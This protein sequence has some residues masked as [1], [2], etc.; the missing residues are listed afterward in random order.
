M[1]EN[2]LGRLWLEGH[3][4]EELQKE[5]KYYLEEAEQEPE[6]EEELKKIR[7]EH[8][9]L[10]PEDIKVLDPCMG[11]GHILV[12]AFD[13]LYQIYKEA[14]YGEREIPRKIL[15]NNLYGLDI[16]DRAAQLA[17][18]ALI[19]KARGYNRRLFR[20]IEREELELNLCSIQESNGISEEAIE[21]FANGNQQ[22]KED[23]EYLV[24]VFNYAKEYGS[25]LE[26]ETVNFEIINKRLVEVEEDERFIFGDYRRTIIDKVPML[27]KQC[28]VISNKYEI[29]VTNP[30]YMGR[31][32]MKD[33]LVAYLDD[34]YQKSKY[35]MSTVFMDKCREY[36]K[37]TGY[38]SMINIPSWMFLS[39]YQGLRLDI[40][41]NNTFVNLLHNGRG[42]FGSDFGTTAFVINNK[43]ISNYRAIFRK[44]FLNQGEVDSVLEKEKMFFN[45]YGVYLNNQ[46]DFKMIES[47]PIAYWATDIMK[48]IFVEKHKLSNYAQPKVGLQTGENEKFLRLWSEVDYSNIGLNFK[49]REIAKLSL[50]KWF[51]YNKGGLFRKWYGNNEYIVNWKN[52][53]EEIRGFKDNKGKLK[54]RPQNLEYYFEEGITWSFVSSSNFGVRYSPNGFIFD[55]AGSS[56]FPR[57]E[58]MY[59]IMAILGSKLSFEFLKVQN[60]TLNF[61]A[62]NIG[63]IPVVVEMNDDVKIKIDT[64]SKEN[65]KISKK[66]WDS[67]ETSWDFNKHPLLGK[68]NEG[69]INEAFD[70]WNTECNNSFQK[71]KYNEEELNRIF[72]DIYGLQDELTPEVEDKDIT[73]RKADR[74]RD[75]RSFISYAVGC[76]FG[77]YSIDVEG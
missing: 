54:S 44:L 36:C 53:G 25:I 51:P 69:K 68:G 5:W 12:Y 7:E 58:Y 1:V 30:P 17:S 47:N 56:V 6:V 3:P 49:S 63:N 43:K 18:F 27:L 59:T 24:T 14:G 74:E 75:I 31:K 62:N 46:E 72:I 13:V 77:R 48:R 28:K 60:P 26:V 15:Q 37:S 61:Q 70:M 45:N 41:N 10:T 34:K 76:M 16:D 65:I 50:K 64:I 20:E 4:N 39:T 29:C 23:I 71:L 19:M 2:S 22:L 35:D 11:S 38:I 33:K 66:D 9:H 55:V 52:D 21:Y 73:I 40:I 67:F 42:V 32:G 8:S 57:R